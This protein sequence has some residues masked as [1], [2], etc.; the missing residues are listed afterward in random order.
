MKTKNYLQYK[1]NQLG[2]EHRCVSTTHKVSNP[3]PQLNNFR[4]TLVY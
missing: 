1:A 2:L 4:L 3:H